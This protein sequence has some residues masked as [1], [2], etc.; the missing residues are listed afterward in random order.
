[1]TRNQCYVI[2]AISAFLCWSADDKITLI[3]FMFCM[4]SFKYL[5]LD[6]SAE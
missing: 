2:C 3:A 6:R 5:F 4:V 1:M